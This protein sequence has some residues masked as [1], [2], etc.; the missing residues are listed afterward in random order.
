MGWGFEPTISI[1][2]GLLFVCVLSDFIMSS[3]SARLSLATSQLQEQYLLNKTDRGPE[4]L[5]YLFLFQSISWDKKSF[6]RQ[7]PTLAQVLSLDSK[8]FSSCL[9]A[10]LLGFALSF[11]LLWPLPPFLLVAFA[12]LGI[13]FL[14]K[15][16]KVFQDLGV[17]ALLFALFSLLMLFLDRGLKEVG[18]AVTPIEFS[19]WIAVVVLILSII[20]FKTIVPFVMTLSSLQMLFGLSHHWWPVFLYAHLILVASLGLW[21]QR[22]NKYQY[23]RL[24]I[25]VLAVGLLVTLMLA[26][27]LNLSVVYFS[28]FQLPGSWLSTLRYTLFLCA[29]YYFGFLV[30]LLFLYPKKKMAKI[31]RV[32]APVGYE[33][34][35]SFSYIVS[36]SRLR[37]EMNQYQKDLGA[38]LESLRHDLEKR[39][40]P[41][42]SGPM[43][44]TLLQKSDGLKELC[45]E[46]GR[47]PSYPEH[48]QEVMNAYRSLNQYESLW[49]DILF[50][51]QQY[52]LHDRSKLNANLV[53]WMN[54]QLDLFE[55]RLDCKQALTATV[56]EDLFE[57][58]YQLIEQ[59]QIPTTEAGSKSIFYRVTD[60][61]VRKL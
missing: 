53:D 15:A 18:L 49:N 19:D 31:E 7:L 27:L 30:L 1:L 6:F 41:Y 39:E 23:L 28:Q 51:I 46:L 55:Q 32:P 25:G 29:I 20:L 3:L 22:K 45:F 52:M 60:G 54:I 59:L 34:G 36:L 14:F 8:Q 4:F 44:L 17:S 58:S 37:Q 16:N 47:K 61:L 40:T 11:L 57:K 26:V 38:T 13:I 21:N 42:K 10:S 43:R 56:E 35:G 12:L 9:V 48:V 50:I 33:E 2:V 24:H 5:F